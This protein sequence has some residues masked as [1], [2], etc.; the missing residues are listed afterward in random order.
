MTL[1][2]APAASRADKSSALSFDSPLDKA[3][4]ALSLA[5]VLSLAALLLALGFLA[6]PSGSAL[7]RTDTGTAAAENSIPGQSSRILEAP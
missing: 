5:A 3:V 2:T 1:P 4:R 7:A 6:L